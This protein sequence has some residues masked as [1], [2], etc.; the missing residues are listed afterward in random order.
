L[1]VKVLYTNSTCAGNL[2]TKFTGGI[3]RQNIQL[4]RIIDTNHRQ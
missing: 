3:Y 4:H 1:S 2:S